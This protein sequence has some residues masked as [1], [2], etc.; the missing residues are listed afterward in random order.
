MFTLNKEDWL[1]VYQYLISL[2]S[3]GST[4]SNGPF[5]LGL[6]DKRVSF[7]TNNN[8]RMESFV[9]DYSDLHHV[10]LIP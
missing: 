3:F 2:S 8:P 4:S 7:L 10:A 5:L 1:K 6:W 9:F